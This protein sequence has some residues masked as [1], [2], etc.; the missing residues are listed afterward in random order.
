M[1]LLTFAQAPTPWHLKCRSCKTKLKPRKHSVLAV[2][3]ASIFGL[4]VA[5]VTLKLPLLYFLLVS[6]FGIITLEILAFCTC[7]L[8]GLDL[9]IRE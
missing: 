3:L 7:K 2:V 8:I 1:S 5:L 6:I 4:T 9:E